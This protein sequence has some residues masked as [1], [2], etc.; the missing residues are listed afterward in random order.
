MCVTHDT[1]LVLHFRSLE[2]DSRLLGI[3]NEQ[4]DDRD[5]LI[6]EISKQVRAGLV[7]TVVYLCVIFFLSLVVAFARGRLM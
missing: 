2:A 1:L 3:L 4:Y 7:P 5:V 6:S